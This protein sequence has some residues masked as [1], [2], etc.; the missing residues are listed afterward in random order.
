MRNLIAVSIYML[1]S[2]FS[3]AIPVNSNINSSFGFFII[4]PKDTEDSIIGYQID[5]GT[6]IFINKFLDTETTFSV[7]SCSEA[8]FSFGPLTL[9]RKF[10]NISKDST[11]LEK[12]DF[13]EDLTKQSDLVAEDNRG[14]ESYGFKLVNSWG[15]NFEN[16]SQN[17][18]LINLSYIYLWENYRNFS[19]YSNV[20]RSQSG[21]RGKWANS[22]AQDLG[23][24]VK[25]SLTHS[26]G[27]I[28]I[29]PTLSIYSQVWN[30]SSISGFIDD[31]KETKGNIVPEI[32]ETIAR[33]RF[34]PIIILDLPIIF[35]VAKSFNIVIT[36]SLESVSRVLDE[37]EVSRM[38]NLLIEDRLSGSAKIGLSYIG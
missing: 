18:L 3:D 10:T 1:S 16:M 31:N 9:K 19:E 25:V 8:D 2:V 11:S 15:I 13:V 34:A 6:K 24:G 29:S 4:A 35:K 12:S 22:T 7:F 33:K 17:W 37:E 36:V 32:S 5:L 26:L 28:D 23:M 27:S 30:R 14:L 38:N 21:A 20:D